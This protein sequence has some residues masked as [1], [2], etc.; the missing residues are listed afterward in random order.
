M[1]TK[2]IFLLA[3]ACM[4]MTFAI[5]QEEENADIQ[6]KM[7]DTWKTASITDEMTKNSDQNKEWRMGQYKYSAKPKNAIE[8][9]IKG[10]HFFIDGD[11]DR[12]LP[13][14]YGVG[15]H[16]R[17]AIHYVF[18]IKGE[19]FY[20]EAKGLDPQPSGANLLPEGNA[21]GIYAGYSPSN[22]WFFSHKTRYIAASLEGVVNIGNLLFHQERNKW[23]WYASFGIGL[24][25]HQT[26]LDL[27]DSNGEVYDNLV[28]LVDW[29]RNKFDT[30]AGR[31]EIKDNLKQVYDGVYETEG[32][33]K[34][35]IFRIGD[36]TNIHAIGTIS[37]GISRKISKRLNIGLEHKVFLS[38]ND[39]LDGQKY[40]TNIDQTNNVDIPHFTNITIGINM[41]NFDKRTE[42]L[43]WLNPLDNAFDDIA[44]LKQ[45]PQLDLTD[46]D[47]DGVIDMLDQELDTPEGCAVDT[48]GIILDSDG[49]G[50]ADCKDLEPYSPPGLEIDENGVAQGGFKT[51]DE[52]AAIVED[53]VAPV[54]DGKIQEI[55]SKFEAITGGA[56]YNS[57]SNTYTGGVYGSGTSPSP[58]ANGATGAT[59]A[60]GASGSIYSGGGVNYASS[61]CGQWFLPMIHFDND[62]S[63]IKTEYYSHLHH[64]AQVLEKCPEICVV[65]HGHTDNKSSND[66]NKVLSYNRSKVSIDYLVD[67]YG[68]DRSRLKLMYGGEE[69]PL[70]GVN[71]THYMNR[72][73]EFRTCD[74]NDFD[75]AEPVIGDGSGAPA[76]SGEVINNYYNGN[77][78]S[79][80]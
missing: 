51:E 20:G 65:A 36:E 13:A 67:N 1:T 7:N 45:R 17:K 62:R 63:K 37:T 59:G 34:K 56:T 42:P 15:L 75:M 79:G 54:V 33:K 38:D 57:D 27:R 23:N 61:G 60:T 35:G 52:I 39:F 6:E 70:G 26:M 18:S 44:S 3:V 25:S 29:D 16:L 71:G 30:Q 22:P 49:D 14:G 21:G 2:R 68:I 46:D 73:V 4:T 10:G 9:G 69:S 78:N 31:I 74:A 50:L 19:L 48:R 28:T 72:R 11:V 40:R 24:D 55:D 47:N 66:Y 53:R 12:E 76:Q 41:G 77:K 32:P 43:Y 80:Y 58:G 8:I 64:V 5:G